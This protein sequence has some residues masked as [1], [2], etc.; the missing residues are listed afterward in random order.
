MQFVKY[1]L[2]SFSHELFPATPACQS[3]IDILMSSLGH[4]DRLHQ[5]L[6]IFKIFS[7][8][9]WLLEKEVIIVAFHVANHFL[10][11]SVF[12]ENLTSITAMSN[13]KLKLAHSRDN[14]KW[15]SQE[16]HA[17]SP[18]VHRLLPFFNIALSSSYTLP[19]CCILSC[20]KAK[21]YQMSTYDY[22]VLGCNSLQTVP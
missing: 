3:V 7:C 1:E 2:H 13:F 22:E 8:V 9:A 20:F 18:L 4:V 5:S 19:A 16:M 17:N 6:L 21:I 15:S 11:S 14:C 10:T 12:A